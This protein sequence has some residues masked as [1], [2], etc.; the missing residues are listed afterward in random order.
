MSKP[1]QLSHHARRRLQQRGISHAAIRATLDW[2]TLVLQR[3]GRCAYYLGKRAVASGARVGVDI[4]AYKGTAVLVATS[5]LVITVLRCANP[6]RL[7]KPKRR[8][9]LRTRRRARAAA[10][11]QREFEAMRQHAVGGER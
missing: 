6:R 4:R 9:R 10:A 11:L 2:G 1:L 3:R 7:R 5:G 8:S